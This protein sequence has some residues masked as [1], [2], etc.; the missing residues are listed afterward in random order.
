MN[1]PAISSEAALCTEDV[2]RALRRPIAV[3]GNGQPDR[4]MG[5]LIDRHATIIR[6]NSFAIS[7]HETIV[8]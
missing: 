3:V 7:G 2:L 4:P 1:P 8:G 6:L 5:G